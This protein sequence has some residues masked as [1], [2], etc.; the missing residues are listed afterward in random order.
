[1]VSVEVSTPVTKLEAAE[2]AVVHTCGR[3]VVGVAEAMGAFTIYP[4][5]GGLGQS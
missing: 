5:D 4:H 1:M 3:C 2:D